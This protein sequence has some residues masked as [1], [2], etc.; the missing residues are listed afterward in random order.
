MSNDFRVKTFRPFHVHVSIASKNYNHR[1]RAE[2]G[3]SEKH[4]DLVFESGIEPGL[5]GGSRKF[6]KG[7]PGHLPTYQL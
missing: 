4:I 6:R 1:P 5:K 3:V 2:L 7:W